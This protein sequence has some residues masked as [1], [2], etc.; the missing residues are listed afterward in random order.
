MKFCF[1]T[2][3]LHT[4][5]QS[6]LLAIKSHIITSN[7][8]NIIAT[9][10]SRGTDFCTW[11]GITCSR[12]HH[13]V[14]GLD[15]F[16]MNLQGTIAREIGNLS[17]LSYLRLSNNSFTGTIPDEIGNLRRLRVLQMIYNQ[18]IGEIPLSIFNHS[19]LQEI[20][21]SRNQLSGSLPFDMCHHLP[22]LESLFLS[23]NQ[24]SGNIPSS[25]SACSHLRNLSLSYNNFTGSI[26]MHIG[27]LSELQRLLLGPNNLT[28]TIPPSI[29]NMSSLTM[30]DLS[31]NN[32]QGKIPTE[33]GRLS[34]LTFLNLGTNKLNGETPQL[35]FNLS[36]LVTLS[37]AGNEL[38]G[39][40]PLFINRGLPNLEFLYLGSNKFN[41]TIPNSIS[42]LSN[43]VDLDLAKNFFIGL[44]P[45]TLGNLL[46]LE[47]LN[48]QGNELTN[49]LSIPEE[50][51]LS[52]LANCK[53]LNQISISNNSI[54]GALLKLI[55]SGN[56]STSL[57]KFYAFDCRIS[58][59]IPYEIGNLSNLIYMGIGNNELTGMIPETLGQMKS[60]Q[61]LVLYINNLWGPIPDSFCN[62]KNLY[63]ANF[64]S[65]RLS[66]QLPR[67]VGNIAS[68][69]ELH[70]AYNAFNSN[71]P[72]TLWS[73]ERILRINFSSNF[74]DGSLS[75]EI[76]TQKGMIVLDLSGNQFSGE[77]PSTIGQLQ[78]LNRL[79]LSN[80]KLHGPI[81]VTF[82]NLKGLEYLDLSN[83][84]LSGE[85]PMSL[86]TLPYLIYFNV[87]FNE[88]SGEIPN[89]G[90]FMNLT[91]E[92]FE[93]NIDL[94]GDSRFK[95]E[96]CKRNALK[97]SS[98]K[99]LLRYILPPISLM[100]FA[101]AIV[102]LFLKYRVRKSSLSPLSDS[103]LD[104]TLKRV[105]Y[106]EVLRATSNLD[107]GNMIGRGSLGSVYKGIFSNGMTVAIKVFNL[108]VQGALKSFDTECQILSSIRHRNLVKVITSCTN[109]DFKALVLEYMPH[110]N[111]D[112]WLYSPNHSLSFAQRLAIM[113]DVAFAIEYLHQGYSSPIVHC[114][115]K[116]SNILLDENMVARVGDFGI[117]KLMTEDQRIA[118]TK[119][120]G[121]MGYMAPEYGSSGIVSASV[122]V[123]SY[124]I[125]LMETFIRKKP[126]DEMFV[127][128][129]T[130]KRWVSDSF[131]RAIMQIADTTL[132][133]VDES[134]GAKVHE[135]CLRS[136]MGL[137]LECTIDVPE[138]RLDIKDVLAR[139][140]KIKFEL[141][142][143]QKNKKNRT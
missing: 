54:T 40:L 8:N 64:M 70:L 121:T 56:L 94:C 59:E 105:S 63:Y 42:N 107:E 2:S 80:N 39:N 100:A 108:D 23:F 111:L 43:L 73:N 114:D 78:S 26:P 22:K 7:P 18:L 20:A 82:D 3:T 95:V 30:L 89:G 25:L 29:G 125:L 51:F 112:K 19:S 79:A 13:R 32:L 67:C 35:V 65:N 103:P 47:Y 28:G 126:T 97:S 122:D 38:S 119:T 123:Y 135:N 90:P 69:Q 138:R 134:I 45:I 137:A 88:L 75:P 124:G 41:G 49:D 129:L 140:K 55:G 72:S 96:A 1:A 68:L 81:P 6:S 85:I 118:Q 62:L 116:P 57:E 44:V 37:L 77:I 76:G 60:L 46:N 16:N 11:I 50:D 15:L 141:E 24:L 4:D 93:G 92:F 136:I 132:L 113:T 91:A 74:F 34:S 127:G 12:R 66:G 86:E 130:M 104:L 120:L 36:R 9:N 115:L 98:K 139:L 10:W 128:D 21:L 143:F 99:R 83:N 33:I 117:A 84:S 52:P 14:T 133:N 5:D 31:T 58:G 131:P 53:Y 71:I 109:L 106:F 17:F 27:N 101:T 142:M 87:S 102:M 61:R 48:L 110:G